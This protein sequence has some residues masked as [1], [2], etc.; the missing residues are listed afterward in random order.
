LGDVTGLIT[1]SDVI[2]GGLLAY[3]GSSFY[4]S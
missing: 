2:V 3:F 4:S 1:F